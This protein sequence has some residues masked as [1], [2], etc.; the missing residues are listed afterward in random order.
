MLIRVDFDT[1][2]LI[3]GLREVRY[4]ATQRKPDLPNLGIS[5]FFVAMPKL[6]LITNVERSMQSL[7]KELTVKLK[8]GQP[9]PIND[10]LKQIERIRNDYVEEKWKR[11]PN[12]GSF[13][14]LQAIRKEA[15]RM[16]QSEDWRERYGGIRA[17]KSLWPSEVFEHNPTELIRLLF[18]LLQDDEARVR[19]S[20]S[21]VFNNLRPFGR[22]FTERHFVQVY[23][24]LI[25]L[26]DRS[27]GRK[28]ESISR[29]LDQFWCPY[30]EAVLIAQG[31]EPVQEKPEGEAA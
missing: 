28:K 16:C 15:W 26:Y 24:N 25:E 4:Y 17:L 29:A 8:T 6:I 30:L 7:I 18:R 20:A 2:L 11:K 12:A 9:G 1:S 5:A 31:F 21:N 14:K 23:E 3:V 22:S 10:A 27:K 13:E 19:Y